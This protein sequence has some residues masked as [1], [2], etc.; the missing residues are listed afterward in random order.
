MISADLIKA[1]FCRKSRKNKSSPVTAEAQ[2]RLNAH[3][4]GA[5][6]RIKKKIVWQNN[7]RIKFVKQVPNNE[8]NLIFFRELLK[9]S[10][11]RC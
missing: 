4:F 6:E 9:K 3:S 5:L 10:E 11:V 7:C 2:K 1:F 8:I